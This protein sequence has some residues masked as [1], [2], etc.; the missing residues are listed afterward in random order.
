MR[1]EE[2]FGAFLRKKRE[3]HNITMLALAKALDV[4]GAYLSDVERGRRLPLNPERIRKA[5]EVLSFNKDEMNQMFDLAAISRGTVAQDILD[6]IKEHDY[7]SRALRLA[8]TLGA[9]ES[10]WMDFVSTLKH[11]N[12]TEV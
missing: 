6:Y 2:R 7:V 11:K 1:D 4:S 9:T 8:R 5:A 12:A 10:D 3:E